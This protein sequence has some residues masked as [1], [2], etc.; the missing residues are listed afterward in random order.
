MIKGNE[1]FEA[2]ISVH[3]FYSLWFSV[4]LCETLCKKKLHGAPRRTTEGHRVSQLKSTFDISV[5]FNLGSIKKS[6]I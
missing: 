4:Y 5:N 3:L 6:V 1:T 2:G